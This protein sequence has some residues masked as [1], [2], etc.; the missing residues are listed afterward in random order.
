MKVDNV[1]KRK[2]DIVQSRIVTGFW[3]VLDAI[4]TGVATNLKIFF[5]CKGN[6]GQRR[7]FINVGDETEYFDFP[8]SPLSGGVFFPVDG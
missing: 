4:V 1:I 7:K 2:N 6:Q 5:L 8:T 3:T